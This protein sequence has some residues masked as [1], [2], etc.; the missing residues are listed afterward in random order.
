MNNL[1]AIDDCDR[2][3]EPMTLLRVIEDRRRRGLRTA[4]AGRDRPRAWA[5]GLKDL[6]TRLEAAPRAELAD[7]G[8]DLLA[9]VLAQHFRTRQLRTARGV[10]AYAAPRIPKTFAA[11][12]AFAEAAAHAAAEGRPITVDLAKT[13]VANLFEGPFQP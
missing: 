8:E 6:E 4:L 7:P 12:A 3:C 1:A 5:R 10:V 9:A 2:A 13:I 11:A